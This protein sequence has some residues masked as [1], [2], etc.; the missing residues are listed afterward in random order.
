M[1]EYNVFVKYQEKGK[2]KSFAKGKIDLAKFAT[3]DRDEVVSKTLEIQLLKEVRGL[4]GTPI[5]S[6]NIESVGYGGAARSGAHA[7][8]VLN[9]SMNGLAGGY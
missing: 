9:P 2:W 1:Q 8:R 4:A 5:C 6:R 7:D 3:N